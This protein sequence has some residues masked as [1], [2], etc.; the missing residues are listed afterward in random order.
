[1][2]KEAFHQLRQFLQPFQVG[3][4]EVYQCRKPYGEGA[5]PVASMVFMTNRPR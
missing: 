3:M 1:M 4:T 5:R 2:R